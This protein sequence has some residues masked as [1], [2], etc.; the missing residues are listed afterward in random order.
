MQGR[1]GAAGTGGHHHGPEWQAHQAAEGPVRH[2]GRL[3]GARTLLQL[4]QIESTC[5]CTG[6]DPQLSRGCASALA[7]GHSRQRVAPERLQVG[8][9]VELTV[10]RG[11][12]TETIRVKLAEQGGQVA[13]SD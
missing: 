7:S 10:K 1:F 11:Q 2:L 8:Q 3:Q 12:R 4:L 5:G 6:W 13:S 9:E